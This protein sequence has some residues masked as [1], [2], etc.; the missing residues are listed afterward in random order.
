MTVVFQWF[1]FAM[2]TVSYVIHSLFVSHSFWLFAFCVVQHLF[3]LYHVC[4]VVASWLGHR[5]CNQE[6]QVAPLHV[7]TL[8]KLFTHMCLCS[9]SSIIWYRPN[10]SDAVWGWE[11]NRRSGVALAMH[12]RLSDYTHLRAQWPKKGIWAPRLR[13]SGVTAR[14]P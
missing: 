5:T 10:G 6:V 11:G 3:F 14:L 12:H 8:G 1:S 9:P 13:Y 7:T 4:G 2:S